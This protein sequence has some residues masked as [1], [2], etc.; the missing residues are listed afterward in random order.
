MK[1]FKIKIFLAFYTSVIVL[2]FV[3]QYTSASSYSLGIY[4]PIIKIKAVLP[5][6]IKSELKIKNLSDY[7]VNLRFVIKPFVANENNTNQ[8]KYLLYADYTTA[9]TNFLQK[10]KILENDQSVSKITLAPKQEKKL[11]LMIDLPKEEKP[12]DHYF[13]L[14]FLAQNQDKLNSSYSQ[15]LGGIAMNVL[16]SIDPQGYK[17]LIADFSTSSLVSQGP[18]KF[19]VKIKNIGDHFITTNGYIL[20]KN[21][22]GQ[23]VGKVDL[24]PRNILAKSTSQILNNPA[25]WSEKFLLGSYTAKLYLTYDNSSNLFGETKFIAI[26]T[27]IIIILTIVGLIAIFIIKQSKNR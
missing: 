9:N 19:N 6:K 2:L 1:S 3:R 10:V 18:I 23:T 20:I 27:K 14:V 4:P 8:V 26:P 25:V 22:F 7:P 13:S 5:A 24:G 21:I 15:I 16:V 11:M 17:A 12:I